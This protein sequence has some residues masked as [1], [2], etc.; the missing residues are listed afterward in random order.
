MPDGYEF[1]MFLHII[2]VFGIAGASA[3]FW[4]AM[5]VM[6]RIA[7]VQELRTWTP[8]AVWSDRA[9]P[10]SSILLILAGAY[11]VQDVWSWGDGWINTSLLAVIAM[12]GAGG[13]LMTPRLR[14]IHRATADSADGPVSSDIRSLINDPV[15]WTVLSSF[16]LGLVAVIWNMTIKPDDAQAGMIILAGF[17]LGG[18]AGYL[19]FAR[20]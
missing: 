12:A 3:V 11:M 7:T 2:G 4:V 15:L 9:F 1:A 14:A 20:N 17:V 5:A 13:M 6:R 16:T 8:V 18:L 19:A 10:V